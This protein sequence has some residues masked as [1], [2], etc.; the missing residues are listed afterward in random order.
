VAVHAGPGLGAYDAGLVLAK[1]TLVV[2]LIRG[3]KGAMYGR[4]LAT[5]G[6]IVSAS[7]W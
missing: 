1:Y 3:F 5:E 7:V 2:A 4:R 6:V